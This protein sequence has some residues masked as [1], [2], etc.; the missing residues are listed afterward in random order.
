MINS[1][2]SEKR[3]KRNWHK[4][5]KLIQLINNKR[6]NFPTKIKLSLVISLNLVY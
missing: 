3:I 1:N 4:I 2:K 6:T 5:I